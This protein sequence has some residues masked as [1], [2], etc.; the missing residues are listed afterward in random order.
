MF[1]WSVVGGLMGEGATCRVG[2]CIVSWVWMIPVNDDDRQAVFLILWGLD[3]ALDHW[4][5]VIF[6]KLMLLEF[7]LTDSKSIP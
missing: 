4:C 1:S 3:R 2:V 7:L 5:D 6:C